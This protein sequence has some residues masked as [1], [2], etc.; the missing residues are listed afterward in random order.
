MAEARPA[1][2]APGLA[3]VVA[4]SIVWQYVAPPSRDRLRSALRRAGVAA[5]PEA[6]IAW[7]RMEPAGDR[8]RPA[9]DALARG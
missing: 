6:P 5:T 2:P 4:H 3:T 8:R 9:P 1:E 7:L